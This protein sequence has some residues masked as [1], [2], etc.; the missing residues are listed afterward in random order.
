MTG[1]TPPT[2]LPAWLLGDDE[3]R[4]ATAHHDFGTVFRLARQRAGISYSQIAAECDI[5]P[6][7]VGTLARGRGKVATFEKIVQICDALRIPGHLAGLAARPWEARPASG[8]TE[9]EVDEGVLRRRFVQVAGLAAAAP[10]VLAQPPGR[11]GQTTVSHLRER[12]ARLRR[13]D[14]VLGGGDTYRLYTAEYQ[15]TKSLLRTG[16]YGDATGRALLALLAEQAQQAGWAAFDG[17][18]EADAVSLYEESRHAARDAGDTNLEGNAFAFLAYQRL[19]GD[20]RAGAEIASR[21]TETISDHTPA[22]VRALLHERRAWACAVASMPT[23]AERSLGAAN[24]ALA[25]ADGQ[26]PPDWAAWVDRTELEIMTGRCWA[27]LRRPLRA[28]PVLEAAL[29]RYDDSYARDKALYSSWLAQAYLM[30]GEAEQAAAVVSR[31]LALSDGVASVRPRKRLAPVLNDLSA[32]RYR[33]LPTV[34]ELL[35]QAR[36]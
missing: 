13:L 25:A 29:A 30:A 8:E 21:A 22:G 3:L 11:I 17:G 28:V 24:G 19:G 23:E 9:A 33:T 10:A 7:R 26:P 36:G 35:D 16:S 2:A 12:T 5:K 32:A 14:D 27:E 6:D 20:R 15:A 1:Y 31:A 4:A 34:A 18:R